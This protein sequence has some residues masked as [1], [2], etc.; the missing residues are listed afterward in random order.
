M[1]FP[2]HLLPEVHQFLF[3]GTT[4]GWEEPLLLVSWLSTMLL[5]AGTGAFGRGGCLLG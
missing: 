1:H 3:V 4:T 5:G 2:L